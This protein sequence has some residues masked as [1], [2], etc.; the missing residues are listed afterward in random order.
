MISDEKLEEIKLPQNYDDNDLDNHPELKKLIEMH[1][2]DPMLNWDD[3]D[4]EETE[5]KEIETGVHT[6]TLEK[7]EAKETDNGTAYLNLWWRLANNQVAF[8]K[9]WLTEKAFNMF[10]MNMSKLGVK[11]QLVNMNE[12][13]EILT[14]AARLLTDKICHAEIYV[15]YTE[16]NGYKNMNVNIN[17]VFDGPMRDDGVVNHATN[18]GIN[19]KEE[20]PF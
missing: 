10:K 4:E 6:A 2:E 1:R 7:A 13:G 14:K 19:T 11:D 15:S 12:F 3:V 16:S 18:V 8:Q 5:Y 17:N 9:V 20:L